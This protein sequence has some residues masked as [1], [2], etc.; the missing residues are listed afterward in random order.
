M[1]GGER[2]RLLIA[3]AILQN[4]P[5]WLLDEPTFNLD[6]ETEKGVLYTLFR[7]TEGRQS[8]WILHH[9]VGLEK[10]DEVIVLG[11]GKVLERGQFIEL[12]T[13][14]GVLTGMLRL[15]NELFMET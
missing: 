9:L 12:T 15:Q 6:A 2:Q 8:V 13:R 1:S 4:P 7:A 3:R 5:I 10:M 14:E 11:G